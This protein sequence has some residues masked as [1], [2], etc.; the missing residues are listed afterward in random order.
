MLW[1][2]LH[3]ALVGLLVAVVALL[4]VSAVAGHIGMAVGIVAHQR[5]LAS[6]PQQRLIWLHHLP[7]GARDVRE[8]GNRWHVYTLTIDGR[9]H[10]FMRREASGFLNE[11]EVV[12][13][14]TG[15]AERR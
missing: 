3:R 13:E 15:E 2:M 5:Y 12:V 11:S 8:L 9:D 10:R 14:V 6:H 4:L 1:R 7:E